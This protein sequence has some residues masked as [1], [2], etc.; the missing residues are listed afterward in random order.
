MLE[1][2]LG[3]DAVLA[4]VLGGRNVERA[5]HRRFATAQVDADGRNELFRLDWRLRLFLARCRFRA[6]E[7]SG[8][9]GVGCMIAVVTG[10]FWLG[11]AVFLAGSA[12][13]F[14]R[15]GWRWQ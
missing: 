4:V 6:T 8:S 5:Y 2:Y 9:V 10:W 13:S 12:S 15:P 14:F 3:L 7:V 11:A 1:L